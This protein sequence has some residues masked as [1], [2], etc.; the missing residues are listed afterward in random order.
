MKTI[1]FDESCMGWTKNIDYNLLIIRTQLDRINEELKYRGYVYLNQICE[2]LGIKWDPSFVNDCYLFENG[3][4]NFQC[5][6]M[7]NGR[8]LIHIS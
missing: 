6:P 4:I 3:L 2:R 1:I 5:E 7:E 8:I